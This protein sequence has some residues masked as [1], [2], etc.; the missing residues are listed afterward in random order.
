MFKPLI[1]Q[2]LIINYQ[3]LNATDPI[4]PEKLLAQELNKL[5]KNMNSRDLF[6]S[7]SRVSG[8]ASIVAISKGRL[9]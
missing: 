7:R 5:V 4:C 2:V 8:I 1:E 6:A 9:L 3:L